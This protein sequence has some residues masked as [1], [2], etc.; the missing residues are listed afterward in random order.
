MDTCS[1]TGRRRTSTPGATPLCE[2]LGDIAADDVVRGIN[3]RIAQLK[4][5][6]P[7]IVAAST[8]LLTSSLIWTAFSAVALAAPSR[9][10][11]ASVV[12]SLAALVLSLKH[13]QS[14]CATLLYDVAE[15]TERRMAALH[16]AVSAVRSSAATWLVQDVSEV[17]P[18]PPRP[19]VLNRTRLASDTP[20]LPHI[21]TN[22]APAALQ[23]ADSTLY[24]FPDRLLVWR[25]GLF[26]AIQYDNL[27]I[28]A[29]CIRFLERERQPS[30][31]SIAS[32]I[33]RSLTAGGTLPIALYGI[34]DFGA[35]TL[36]ARLMTSRLESARE[37]V[38][39]MRNLTGNAEVNTQS[40]RSLY[41]HFDANRQS[42]F[43]DL[44]D[45]RIR[46]VQAIRD[47]FSVILQSQYVWRYEDESTDDWKRNAG[48]GT[49]INRTRVYPLLVDEMPGFETNAAVGLGVGDSVLYVFPDQC[50]VRTG[51]SYQ[52]I[53]KTLNVSTTT[54]RFREEEVTPQDSERIG[55]TWRYVNKRGGPDL[56]FNGNRQIPIFRYG[57]IVLSGGTSWRVR[58]CVSRA[59]IASRFEASMRTAQGGSESETPAGS[60]A[61]DRP[62]NRSV[63]LASAFRVLGLDIGASFEEASE[64]YRNLAAQNHPDKVAHMAREFRELADLRMRELNGAFEQIRLF[65]RQRTLH[66]K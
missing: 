59:E 48:A 22:V 16:R 28:R 63:E 29:K 55:T 37:F 13:R 15:E 30:D 57:E 49:L 33:P 32:T 64:A 3:K 31:A 1:E 19:P 56:R 61:T 20:P 43:Y 17:T 53:G 45:T 66:P 51:N 9:W 7:L 38:E 47:A 34:I 52:N 4:Y 35:P 14:K 40:A 18:I 46:R 26:S 2:L 5:T 23:L 10:Q 58:L 60:A 6:V 36:K 50:V 27:K 21:R 54:C 11:I 62:G 41:T 24:F 25:A 12:A 44:A 8:A 39:Q 42:L 65:F